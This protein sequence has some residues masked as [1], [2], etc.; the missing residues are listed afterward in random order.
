VKSFSALVNLIEMID[1][2][3]GYP[4]SREF[5]STVGIDALEKHFPGRWF[6]LNSIP[7]T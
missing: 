4:S 2:G 1:F 3:T 6:L 7:K 5:A